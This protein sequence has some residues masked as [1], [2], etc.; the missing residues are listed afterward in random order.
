MKQS[1]N[2]KKILREIQYLRK[3]LL[4]FDFLNLVFSKAM[5]IELQE[6]FDDS[7]AKNFILR[8]LDRDP[9]TRPSIK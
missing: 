6:T 3:I 1:N 5:L 7:A 2:K 8:C 9:D 4:Y